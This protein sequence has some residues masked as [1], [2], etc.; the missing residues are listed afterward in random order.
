MRN[1]RPSIRRPD[2]I[3]LAALV[4]GR[5]LS[6]AGDLAFRIVLVSAVADASRS[7]FLVGVVLVAPA[8]GALA[9]R[10]R[11]GLAG[12]APRALARRA[13][14]IEL[15]RALLFAAAGAVPRMGLLV[16]AAI[17]SGAMQAPFE[18]CFGALMG[19]VHGGGSSRSAN[20]WQ[21]S[22]AVTAGLLSACLV[23]RRPL[24]IGTAALLDAATF[25]A[26]AVA[27]AAS[28]WWSGNGPLDDDHRRVPA[29]EAAVLAAPDG[30]LIL[31]TR[32][33]IAAVL[34]LAV[35]APS[36]VLVAATLLQPWSLPTQIAYAVYS[37][38]VSAGA[39]AGGFVHVI[40]PRKLSRRSAT[41]AA[42]GIAATALV[43]AVRSPAAFL[44]M[45][46]ASGFA[47]MVLV[48]DLQA[49]AQSD[50]DPARCAEFLSRLRGWLAIV[51]TVGLGLNVACAARTA[52]VTLVALGSLASALAV[53]LV[54]TTALTSSVT[55][56]F[57]RARAAMR[58]RVSA[59]RA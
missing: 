39:L 19:R 23:G 28:A 31:M 54:G 14:S 20:A 2:R 59:P 40:S 13:F 9:F 53:I 15:T 8:L 26:S 1:A 7:T 34:S 16:A 43:L 48:V 5:A 52:P 18:G 58:S 35:A 32:R 25:C 37:A 57:A 17:V 49:R 46:F 41:I 3:R 50:L 10:G 6:V 38:A 22:A 47:E 29:P 44:S 11:L 4:L 33:Y 36:M 51:A 12:R 42:A 24:G 45:T 56:V 30:D 27:V 55:L 21:R